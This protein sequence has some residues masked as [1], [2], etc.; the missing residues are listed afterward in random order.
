MAVA[1]TIVVLLG[2]VG[3]TAVDG[4]G[5]WSH[6]WRAVSARWRLDVGAASHTVPYPGLDGPP[7][8]RLVAVG[9]V[10]TGGDAEYATAEAVD[11]LDA[12][13]DFD[14]LL[15]LGDN[16]Y[17]DGDPS[18]VAR[19]V[20]RPFAPVLDGRTRLL[21]VLGNHDVETCDGRPE[22]AALSMP[23]RWY[24]QR[25]GP[26]EVVAVDST[27]ADDPAQ[28]AWLERTLADQSAPW[29][30]VIQHH[31]PFSA[32]YHGSHRPS[33]RSLVPLY[34]RHGVDLVLAGHDHDYQRT[35][36]QHGVVYVVSGAAAKR[37]PTAR[38]DFTA[39]A[40]STYEFVELAVYADRLQLRAVDQHGGVFDQTTLAQ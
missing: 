29:T 9:D 14:A 30:V 6:I 35:K 10:G 26:V 24:A 15:L 38:A 25:I 12:G 18:E 31:P 7:L 1:A 13:R 40:A 36:P 20:R 11:R 23:G 3:A 32:G 2:I 34:E 22:M 27:R 28:L 17:P 21:A 5:G 39:M 4:A 37:R 19:V 33:D 16:V 8:A